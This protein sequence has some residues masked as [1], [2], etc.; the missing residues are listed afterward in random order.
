MHAYRSKQ[1]IRF[2]T[3]AAL[4]GV[5]VF[6]NHSHL[7]L[8]LPTRAALCLFLLSNKHNAALVGR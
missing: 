1:I 2:E 3:L 6:F 5:R 4:V 8:S 7:L